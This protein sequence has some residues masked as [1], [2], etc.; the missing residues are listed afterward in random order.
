[1]SEINPSYVWPVV[2]DPNYKTVDFDIMKRTLQQIISREQLM[3]V[4][5][6]VANSYFDYVA[7]RLTQRMLAKQ[8]DEET[9]TGIESNTDKSA[10]E[11]WEVVPANWWS[12][13]L[14]AIVGGV[15]VDY[16]WRW[17]ILKH[18]KLRTITIKTV[19][20]TNVTNRHITKFTRCCPH[21]HIPDNNFHIRWLVNVNDDALEARWRGGR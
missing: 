11:D 14:V 16:G 1:M 6:E 17:K 7:V 20:I 10:I 19:N 3:N 2:P 18:A 21:V 5:V 13:V 4:E 15:S 9:M 12:H 8:A